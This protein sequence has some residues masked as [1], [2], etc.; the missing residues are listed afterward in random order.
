[1]LERFFVKPQTVDAIMGCWLASR[2]D[3]YVTALCE[4][5][6]AVRSI[7][8][9]VPILTAFADFTAARNID[10]ADQAEA[11]VEAFAID[12]LCSSR[13]SIRGCVST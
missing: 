3:Q 9:R 10:H 11:L 8:R 1:M 12:W 7:Y 4:Q 6:F 5:G 2:I 13:Q